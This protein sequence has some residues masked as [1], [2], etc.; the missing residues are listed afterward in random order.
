[1]EVALFQEEMI[2]DTI[3][4]LNLL[5]KVLV[6]LSDESLLQMPEHFVDSVCDVLMG[7]AKLKSRL[8]RGMDVRHVFQLMVK[9]LSPNYTS[10][11]SFT[12]SLHYPNR[13][14]RP[15]QATTTKTL[16]LWLTYCSIWIYSNYFIDDP[17]LQSSFCSYL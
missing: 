4:F 13:F 11:S 8:L 16:Q 12:P 7:V 17:Q 9:L 5:S 1:M 10:V 2:T 6:S 3:R 14:V 15:W